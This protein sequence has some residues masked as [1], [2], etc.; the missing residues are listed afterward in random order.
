M[1]VANLS[2]SLIVTWPGELPVERQQVIF[3][4]IQTALGY[5]TAAALSWHE[6][7]QPPENHMP[8]AQT[9]GPGD[10]SAVCPSCECTFR[11]GSPRL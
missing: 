5:D 1:P 7:P 9:A 2:T 11:L 6:S 4:A 8:A 3:E 10:V